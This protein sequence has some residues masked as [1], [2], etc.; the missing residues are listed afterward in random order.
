MDKT[1]K[2]TPKTSKKHEKTLILQN[3]KHELFAQKCVDPKIKS[4]AEAYADVYAVTDPKIS[5]TNANKLLKNA[6]IRSRVL[7]LLNSNKSTRMERLTER[8]GEH[9]ES[10][11]GHIS[12]KAV[13]LGWKLHG[14]LDLDNMNTSE[15]ADININI[16]T[17]ASNTNNLQQD[18]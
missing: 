5:S 6:D 13:E 3:K 18:G 1:P 12:L 10:E 4:P 17:N 11:E 7:E 2:N 8:L 9:V 16:I 14:A 15:P